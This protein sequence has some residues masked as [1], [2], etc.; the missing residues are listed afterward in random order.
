[1]TITDATP[2]TTDDVEVPLGTL[3]LQSAKSPRRRAATQA[4]VEEETILARDDVRSI[5]VVEE[6]GAPVCDWDRLQGRLYTLGLDERQRDFLGLVL[7]MVGIGSYTL[8]T[9]GDLDERHLAILM[10]AIPQLAGNDR[11]AVGTR[12]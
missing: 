1:M 11:L 7:G 6:N 12:L 9:A 2:E 3:L 5:L 10:R 4:L 8:A